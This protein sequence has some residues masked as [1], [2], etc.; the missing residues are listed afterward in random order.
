MTLERQR[1]FRRYF[2]PLDFF[3]ARIWICNPLDKDRCTSTT[4]TSK[5]PFTRQK[6]WARTLQKSGMDRIIFAVYTDNA[7]PRIGQKWA[8]DQ[9]W[10]VAFTLH[11]LGSGRISNM[12]LYCVH[13][14]CKKKK[15]NQ[16]LLIYFFSILLVVEFILILLWVYLPWFPVSL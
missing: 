5:K 10:K 4:A 2:T 14:P 6:N 11:L 3:S 9:A 13:I 1:L 7:L 8:E 15:Y 16:L 12:T